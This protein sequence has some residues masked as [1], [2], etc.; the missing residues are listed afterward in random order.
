MMDFLIIT[1]LL[2]AN[3]T[4]NVSTLRHYG[5]NLG[6]HQPFQA[7]ACAKEV[8]RFARTFDAWS[9]RHPSMLA[10]TRTTNTVSNNFYD[11]MS[12][13][14]AEISKPPPLKPTLPKKKHTFIRVE[15]VHAGTARDNLVKVWASLNP[16][17]DLVKNLLGRPRS[18]SNESQK[19]R[20]WWKVTCHPDWW[21][22]PKVLSLLSFPDNRVV[23]VNA[24]LNSRPVFFSSGIHSEVQQFL[25]EVPII[26]ECEPA[27][28]S[29]T[30]MLVMV[31]G[32][33]ACIRLRTCLSF[34]QMYWGVHLPPRFPPPSRS[35]RWGNHYQDVPTISFSG[36]WPMNPEPKQVSW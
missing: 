19:K 20:T 13:I 33:R 24:R 7:F 27:L 23:L 10:S 6:F 2:L 22:W 18:L 29:C 11:S 35:T 34:V 28:S 3:R 15:V 16:K 25:K 12:N 5:C 32:V 36:E 9:W 26:C 17:I 8:L 4:Q 1:G 31:A 30:P 14:K 21:K